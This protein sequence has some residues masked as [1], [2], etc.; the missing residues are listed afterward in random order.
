MTQN[1]HPRSLPGQITWSRC[2]NRFMARLPVTGPVP[3]VV[4]LILAL[5]LWQW[6]HVALAA[7]WSIITETVAVLLAGFVLVS[8]WPDLPEFAPKATVEDGAV[9]P[10]RTGNRRIDLQVQSVRRSAHATRERLIQSI[11][12]LE[13]RGNVQLSVGVSIAILTAGILAWYLLA[14]IHDDAGSSCDRLTSAAIRFVP[15]LSLAII[16]E[17]IAFYFF[18]LYRNTLDAIQYLLNELT[19]IDANV[20]AI[21]IA[22]GRNDRVLV[23]DALSVL[24]RTD[25][26]GRA[27]PATPDTVANEEKSAKSLRE[28]VIRLVE[29]APKTRK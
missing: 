16:G 27:V 28:D 17:L 3:F 4:L 7:P 2:R 6:V 14:D 1:E 8:L 5:G 19:T 18:K 29:T 26:N 9:G 10:P 21:E 15:R 12:A 11:R 20:L 22:V 23:K 24:A 25:R 13:S